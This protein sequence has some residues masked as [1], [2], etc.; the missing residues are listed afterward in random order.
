MEEE[1]DA[2][3]AQV[4]AH[5][6]AHI[7]GFHQIFKYALLAVCSVHWFNPL[8]WVLTALFQKDMELAADDAALR[9]LG[10]GMARSYASML[11]EMEERL[12]IPGGVS[13]LGAPSLQERLEAIFKKKS[14]NVKI[15]LIIVIAFFLIFSI[16]SVVPSAAMAKNVVE[17]HHLAYGETV[18]TYSQR[19]N[20]MGYILSPY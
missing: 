12:T 19:I 5:E 16:I 11:L 14:L 3:I 4:L 17:N 7:R 20:D 18:N 9:V 10:P 6:R 15:Q 13:A 2:T 1:S 8:V